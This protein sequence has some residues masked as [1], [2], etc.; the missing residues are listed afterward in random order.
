MGLSHPWSVEEDVSG[1]CGVAIFLSEKKWIILPA[2]GRLW[3]ISSEDLNRSSLLL[4]NSDEEKIGYWDNNDVSYSLA[5]EMIELINMALALR[6]A[7]LRDD[8]SQDPFEKSRVRENAESLLL[9]RE[10]GSVEPG[11]FDV[12]LGALARKFVGNNDELGNDEVE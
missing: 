10:W 6:D 11:Q 4:S 2:V 12:H 7:Q 3:K 1:E 5:D 9:E 8:D